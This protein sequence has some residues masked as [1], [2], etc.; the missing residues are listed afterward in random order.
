VSRGHPLTSRVAANRMWQELFGTGIVE[1]PENFGTVGARPTNRALLDWLAVDFEESGW[2]M[3]RFYK[4]V[5]MSATYRQSA[6]VSPELLAA[7]PANKLLGR[8]PRFRLDAEMLRDQALCASG[9][10]VEKVG[11]P[12]TRPYQAPGIWEA[13]AVA[14]QSNTR[15]YVLD[16][17]GALYRRSVYTFW[18]RSAPNPVL[19]TFDAPK[20]DVC[21]IRRERSNTPLQALVTENAP[22]YLE[23]SR[24]LATQALHSADTGVDQKLNLIALRLLNRPLPAAQRQTLIRSLERFRQHFSNVD[25]ARAFLAI[26]ES[27]VDTTLPPTDLAAWTLM[28]SQLIN[29]DFALNK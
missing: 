21:T 7:D 28:A 24:Q 8:G 20:R 5:V 13:V 29:S 22:D 10:L 12:S 9:L 27:P 11:G 25:D 18:K 4:Q 17:G 23:A 2:D 16:K 26:G 3:K 15:D 14:N 1:T 6:R 19:S